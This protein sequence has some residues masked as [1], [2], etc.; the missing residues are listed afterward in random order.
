LK[1]AH[2]KFQILNFQSLIQICCVSL[3]LLLCFQLFLLLSSSAS[4]ADDS[5]VVPVKVNGA[6]IT[7]AEVE[8]EVGRI[9]PQTLFHRNVSPEKMEGLRKEAIERLIDKELVFQEAKALG[10]KAEKK[11]VKDKIEDIKKRFPSK[12]EFND[13]LKKSKLSIR[14]LEAEI[15]K[16]LIIGKIFQKEVEDKTK[17]GDEE[18]KTH[19]D[20]NIQRY[21]EM[22][23]IKLRHIMIRF[24]K[25]EGQG[26][27]GKGQEEKEQEASPAPSDAGASG[28]TEP[29]KKT[30]KTRTKEEA[31][32]M[33][34][35]LM[36]KLKEG[37][38]FAD[39][40][41]K[42]S[43]DPYKVKGGDLGYVHRGRMAPEVENVAFDMKIGEIMGPVETE[44]G[45]YIIKVE[46]KQQERQ[47]S[48]DEAREKI[49]KELEGKKKE[50][51]KKEWLS[52]LRH[53][54]KIEYQ[55]TP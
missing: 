30:N 20:N 23:R 45:F 51:R 27:G 38:D 7:L 11:D 55:Q 21:K 40:A 12:K 10:M 37:E 24:D 42:Y 14:G 53:K 19:Y 1:N 22:E 46:D 47:L 26:L 44:Q 13:A 31:R 28:K 33:A 43:E 9:I 49:K 34:K 41:Y 6:P 48:F 4:V 32:V 15:E 8:E 2:C 16:D 50:E 54:A 36:A 35:E 25:S 52:A 5:P 29:D 18:I 17:A 3:P 39:I